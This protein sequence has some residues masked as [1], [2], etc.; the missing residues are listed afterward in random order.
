MARND[1]QVGEAIV[2]EI[3]DARAPAD[4]A[5]F[6]AQVRGPSSVL[7]ICFTVVVIEDVSVIGEVGLEQIEVAIKIVIADSDAH[8]RLLHAAFAASA[9]AQPS[10][11]PKS[12]SPLIQQ[13]QPR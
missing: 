13:E 1:E 10:F 6:N 2:I 5:S 9:A 4:P 3:D 8:A 7:E 12:P 11:L